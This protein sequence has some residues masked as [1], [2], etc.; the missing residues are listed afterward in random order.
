M[1]ILPAI[2]R[3]LR[4]HPLR[5]RALA[6]LA[7]LLVVA[8]GIPRWVMHAVD[9]QHETL[10]TQSVAWDADEPHRDGDGDEADTHVCLHAHYFGVQPCT[11]PATLTMQ[12]RALVDEFPLGTYR[13][14]P[15]APAVPPQRPPI[16]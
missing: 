4:R 16:A 2:R 12:V 9:A 8:G 11:L 1:R 5:F 10:S 14:A 13:R 6:M 3:L 7:L 15:D